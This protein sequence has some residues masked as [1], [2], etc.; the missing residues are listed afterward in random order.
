MQ[1]DSKKDPYAFPMYSV[2]GGSVSGGAVKTMPLMVL[3]PRPQ[4]G[5]KFFLS[6]PLMFTS[7]RQIPAISSKNR[8]ILLPLCELMAGTLFWCI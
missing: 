6:G 8:V 5:S 4:G 3:A 7:G 2:S 1:A